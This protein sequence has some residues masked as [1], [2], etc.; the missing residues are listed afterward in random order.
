MI[1][2][3]VAAA[4][5]NNVIG[6]NNAL[7]WRMPADMK[8]FRDVTMGHT[9]VMGRKTYES[10]MKP[11]AGRKNM[12]ITRNEGYK[13]EGCIMVP[14]LIEVRQ[15]CKD[16]GEVF[17]IGGAEIYNLSIEIADK[18]YLTRIHGHFEGDAYFPDIHADKWKETARRDFKAD[19]KNPFDYSFIEYSRIK[20]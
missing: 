3:L 8:F 19:E 6:K 15:L 18:I 5:D 10:M 17:I 12:V 16:E 1:L 4:S 14:S 2:S 13:A 7:P 20:K 11:L 9:V